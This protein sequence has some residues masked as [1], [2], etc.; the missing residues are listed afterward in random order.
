MG[1]YIKV[2][3]TSPMERYLMKTGL[4]AVILIKEIAEIKIKYG[5]MT[6]FLMC[7]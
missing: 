2:N 5:C 3:R 4:L 7:I 6:I 1:C